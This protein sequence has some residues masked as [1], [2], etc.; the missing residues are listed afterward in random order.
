MN[1][2]KLL[3]IV[4]PRKLII[5]PWKALNAPK[6]A[7]MDHCHSRCRTSCLGY[8]Q[9]TAQ[10][11]TINHFIHELPHSSYIP[12]IGRVPGMMF[13]NLTKPAS[14]MS[15]TSELDV[16]DTDWSTNHPVSIPATVGKGRGGATTCGAGGCSG[17]GPP[18]RGA[19]TVAMVHSFVSNCSNF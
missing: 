10:I 18:T 6:P 12:W 4:S 1:K 13:D 3:P 9:V 11:C 2:G 14:R 19:P 7:L 16:T 17:G 15:A 8:C 5:V